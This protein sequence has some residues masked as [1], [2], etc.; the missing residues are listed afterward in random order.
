[1]KRGLTPCMFLAYIGVDRGAR[2]LLDADLRTQL[3]AAMTDHS[4]CLW[5]GH[6]TVAYSTTAELHINILL[7]LCSCD[8]WLQTKRF[9]VRFLV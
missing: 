6:A 2:Y 7:S 5:H 9:R 8:L 4:T 3:V 1:M